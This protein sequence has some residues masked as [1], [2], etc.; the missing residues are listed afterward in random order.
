MAKHRSGLG[1]IIAVVVL[2]LL[3][4]SIPTVNYEPRGLFLPGLTYHPYK[5]QKP[6]DVTWLIYPPA[7]GNYPQLGV[8]SFQ[9]TDSDSSSQKRELIMN[10]MKEAA[11]KVGGNA[12]VKQQL[13][14]TGDYMGPSQARWIG[15]AVVILVPKGG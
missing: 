2:A 13:F 15:T 6:S 10:A 1:F 14:N 9:L 5:A 12:V 7:W 11:A 8:V 4:V 3:Y